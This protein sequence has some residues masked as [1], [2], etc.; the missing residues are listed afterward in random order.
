MN[1]DFWRINQNS[2]ISVINHNKIKEVPG[3]VRIRRTVGK[4]FV[5]NIINFSYPYQVVANYYMCGIFTFQVISPVRRSD[6][7]YNFRI[8]AY[9]YNDFVWQQDIGDC[10]DPKEA[11]RSAL[12]IQGHGTGECYDIEG[13]VRIYDVLGN[14]K[15]GWQVNDIS[16]T[17]TINFRYPSSWTMMFEDL[18]ANGFLTSKY[19]KS[20]EIDANGSDDKTVYINWAD[21]KPC[22]EV[23]LHYASAKESVKAE[24]V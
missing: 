16:L 3:G 5:V 18:Q 8:K 17:E 19:R 9:C 7:S 22:M 12:A 11:I 20:F 14:N 13:E 21:G 4:N 23:V 15:D 2:K 1:E 10:Y 6:A 24:S